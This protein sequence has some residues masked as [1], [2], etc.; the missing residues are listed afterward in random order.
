[1]RSGVDEYRRITGSE[2]EKLLT[3][4][5]D[6]KYKE[7]MRDFCIQNFYPDF[8]DRSK[9]IA[10]FF[11]HRRKEMYCKVLEL[12]T[13][14]INKKFTS[15][16]K[17]PRKPNFILKS[18][19]NLIIK[20]TERMHEEFPEIWSW[21]FQDPFFGKYLGPIPENMRKYRHN[22]RT[23]EHIQVYGELKNASRY[24]SEKVEQL[25]LRK[26][27][28]KTIPVYSQ[29]IYSINHSNDTF[30]FYV[31]RED[32]RPRRA[33]FHT[34]Q[35]GRDYKSD[36]ELLELH[37]II[38]SEIQRTERESPENLRSIIKKGIKR[39]SF[40]L[41]DKD[42]EYGRFTSWYI[43]ENL[44]GKSENYEG[45]QGFRVFSSNQEAFFLT[46]M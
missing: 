4:I 40:Y 11:P 14:E 2:S 16:D 29:P 23:N 41:G 42:E 10:R 24:L 33:Y 17:D 28:N 45:Y 19:K 43:N 3:T 20:T 13:T 34:H 36:K 18:A 12:C 9:D 46:K 6:I 15:Y 22:W 5:H 32:D 27:K 1:M 30:T 37:N 26:E 21:F 35:F 39:I 8:I 7:L 25:G 31:G 44:I 38:N